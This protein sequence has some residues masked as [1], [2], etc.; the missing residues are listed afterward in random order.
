MSAETLSAVVGILLSL[1]F[2]YIPGLDVWFAGLET[3]WKQSIM[4]VSLLVVAAA[5]FGM[6]CTTWAANWNIEL[7]CDQPGLQVLITN[8]IAALVA[9]QSAYKITPQT[10]RVSLAKAA[11]A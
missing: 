9:N 7:T 8:L 11:R 3:K 4:G 2:S 5:V 1:V 10:E 6:S